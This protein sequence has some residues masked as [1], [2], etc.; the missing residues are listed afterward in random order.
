MIV[1]IV[2]GIYVALIK[3]VKDIAQGSKPTS[4]GANLNDCTPIV[5]AVR[6]LPQLQ[7][8]ADNELSNR[9]LELDSA[10]YFVIRTDTAASQIVAGFYTNTIN[11]EGM[12]F[13]DCSTAPS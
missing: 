3:F 4:D 12:L 2:C 8:E 11:E 9:P 6:R 5:D 1:I 7:H 10:G 13:G